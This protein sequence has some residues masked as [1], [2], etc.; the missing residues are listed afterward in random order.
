MAQMPKSAF[1]ET[2]MTHKIVAIIP[3]LTIAMT[4]SA[5]CVADAKPPVTLASLQHEV[6]RARDIEEIQNVMAR[7]AFYHSIGHNEEELALWAKK[8]PVRWAQN[9]GCWIGMASL[10]VYYDDVNRKMQAA[11]LERLSKVNPDIKNI[12]ENRFIGNTILHLLTT[13][14]IEVADDGQTAKGLWYTPGIIL[15][16]GDG[17]TPEGNWIWERY[18]VDFIR[19]DGKW[20]I[21][22]VQVNTDFM[23]PVGSPLQT[24]SG[25]D[26]AAMGKE[27]ATPAPMPGPAAAGIT[28]PGPDI[29]KPTFE[30]YSVTRVPTITPRLPV[31]YRT[32][33]ETFEYADCGAK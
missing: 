9:Q 23:S 10:K 19:E 26:A 8:H 31:P 16:P 11:E 13:P 22:H 24:K 30:E 15:A 18:G 2:L 12:P 28:I 7:R 27:G 33:S 3:A 14:L 25:R 21:L 5:V 32:L 17:K 1:K 4:F 29:P 20:T 6:Q